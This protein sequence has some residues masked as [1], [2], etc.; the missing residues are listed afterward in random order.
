MRTLWHD[1]VFALRMARR[2]RGFTAV[3]LLSLA[4]GIAANTLLF[5]LVYAVLLRPL[6]YEQPDRLLRLIHGTDETYVT[7]PEFEFWKD[8]AKSFES[9]GAYRYAGDQNLQA[10]S[11]T[12]RLNTVAVSSAFFRTLGVRMAA[13]RDFDADETRAGGPDAVILTHKLWNT[14]F[15]GDAA[16]LGRTII[17]GDKP[18]AVAG[19]LPADFWFPEP[20]DAFVPLRATGSVADTGT[21]TAMIARLRPNVSVRQAAAE[22]AA[23]QEPFRRES[24]LSYPVPLEDQSLGPVPFQYWLTGDVRL[25]LL[26]IFAAAGVLFVIACANLAS[27]VLARLV[28]REREIAVRLALGS[29]RGRLAGQFL[30]E[31]LVLAV[32]G[33]AFGSLIA[34]WALPAVLSLIPFQ[35]PAAGQIRLNLPVMLFTSAVSVAAGVLLSVVPCWSS[36]RMGI[37]DALKRGGRQG[38]LTS[39][40]N[41]TRTALVTG[42]I[43]LS[44]VLLVSALLLSES[45]YHLSHQEL[46]FNPGHLTTFHLTMNS[47]AAD[48]APA[49]RSQIRALSERFATLSGVEDVAN[50]NFLPFGGPNNYPT[51]RFG[52]PEQSIG[53]MEIRVVGPKYFETMGIPIRA[54]RGF[55]AADSSGA[56]PVIAISE[57]VARRWWPNGNTIGDLIV[58]GLFQ[59]QAEPEGST[60]NSPRTIVGI[61]GD[62]RTADIKERPR[63]TVYI[64]YT[65]TDDSSTWNW[66]IRGHLPK[67]F[68]EQLRAAAAQVDPRFRVQNLVTM[69]D[70]IAA[71]TA[72]SRFDALLFGIF[73]GTAVLLACIGIFGLLSFSVLQRTREI[74]TRLALGAGSVQVLGLVLRDGFAIL[75]GGLV[76]GIGA[77]MGATRFLSKL[78]FGVQNNSVLT[79]VGAGV[80]LLVVGML[81]SYLPARRAMKIDPLAALRSE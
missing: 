53:G 9:A 17:L 41:R 56:T 23:L 42:Q 31:N 46:G 33:A 32:G 59:G 77:A 4:L 20:V 26:V 78:L 49:M 6:P 40:R 12:E 25:V 8:H 64:P 14:A 11:E 27:L 74:G 54:G 66:I 13:G 55:N 75:T 34:W 1:L 10:G 81:A 80:L 62:A 71:I 19:I 72:D 44:V 76:L 2:N 60:P 58:V 50:V 37:H 7:M 22:S 28:D 73:A 47:S 51:Q 65:Q 29:S 38:G 45:L 43:G 69:D 21:N 15:G 70:T 67:G 68:A 5:T 30:V 57:T 39:S 24:S 36:S 3:A 63:P 18:S 79:Y 35:L 48:S 61:V 52:H 16:L